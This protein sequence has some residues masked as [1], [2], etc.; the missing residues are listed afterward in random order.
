MAMARTETKT[1]V[2]LELTEFE[3]LFLHDLLYRHVAGEFFSHNKLQSIANALENVGYY[4]KRID[5]HDNT[6]VVYSKVDAIVA[7]NQG[8][9]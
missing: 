7:K 6:V 5:G 2:T 3:A 1:V 9:K 8:G 4:S